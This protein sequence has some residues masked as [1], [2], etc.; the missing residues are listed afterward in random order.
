MKTKAKYTKEQEERMVT[1]YR[2]IPA[3]DMSINAFKQRAEI[4]TDIA[5]IFKK[6]DR[7]IIAKLAKL[8]VYITQPKTSKVTGRAPETKEAMVRRLETKDGYP[9]GD[10]SGLEK[11]PKIVLQKLLEE[12]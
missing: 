9:M 12:F 5:E 3:E 2:G 10:Y 7:M 1:M 6:T 4:V 8:K 11:A